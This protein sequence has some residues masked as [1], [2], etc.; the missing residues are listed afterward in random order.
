MVSGKLVLG[1][2][3]SF[4]PFVNITGVFLNASVIAG[5]NNVPMC[6]AAS[7]LVVG[8]R[9]I[10]IKNRLYLLAYSSRCKFKW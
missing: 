3:L 5:L 4:L 6:G 8:H 2:L 7:N 10:E 9:V 1:I